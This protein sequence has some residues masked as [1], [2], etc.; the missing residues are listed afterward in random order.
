MYTS[1]SIIIQM[2]STLSASILTINGIG[3][4]T[5]NKLNKHGIFTVQDLMA[6]KDTYIDGVDI[7][8]FRRQVG[9]RIPHT[10]SEITNHSWFGKVAHI[11]RGDGSCILARLGELICGNAPYIRCYWVD[12]NQLYRKQVSPCHIFTVHVAVISGIIH[13]GNHS[14]PCEDHKLAYYSELNFE[15][16]L[17]RLTVSDSQISEL[18]GTKEHDTLLVTLHSINQLYTAIL[19]DV[20]TQSTQAQDTTRPS[21]PGQ[22]TIDQ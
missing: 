9:K 20:I 17:P 22:K 8:R 7:S 15:Y 3:A 14:D 21:A 4:R 2:T 1:A 10:S 16:I 6:S 13:H 5:Q 12:G 18:V 19:D 11:I